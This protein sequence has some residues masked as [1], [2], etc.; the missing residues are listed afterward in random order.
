MYRVWQTD[1]GKILKDQIQAMLMT[2]AVRDPREAAVYNA[3]RGETFSEE[4]GRHNAHAFIH[5]RKR[6]QDRCH[7][8]LPPSPTWGTNDLLLGLLT[9]SCMEVR[10]EGVSRK[11][12]HR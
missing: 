1:R 9:G 7:Y 8:Q 10:K 3:V 2:E 11:Q 5:S 4:T 12:L 6:I